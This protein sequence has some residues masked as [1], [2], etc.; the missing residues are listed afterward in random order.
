MYV[1]STSH[2]LILLNIQTTK[3]KIP[4]KNKK[5]SAKSG[6]VS[7]SLGRSSNP[8]LLLSVWPVSS[9]KPG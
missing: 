3:S 9:Y 1:I 6:N 4:I 7:L 5:S 2:S 8:S